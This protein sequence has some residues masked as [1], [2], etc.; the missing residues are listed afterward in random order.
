VRGTARNPMN[1]NEV[2]AKALDLLAPVLGQARAAELITKVGSLDRVAAVSE[3]RP[4]L[5][6]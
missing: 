5:Q 2:E 1:T 4:L 3:L 6:A